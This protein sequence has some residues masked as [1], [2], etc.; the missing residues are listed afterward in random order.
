T[1]DIQRALTKAFEDA[2]PRRLKHPMR[3]AV[4]WWNDTLTQLRRRSRKARR[5]TKGANT[6]EPWEFYKKI[7]NEYNNAVQ[8][9]KRNSWRS[10]CENIEDLAETARIYKIIR[11][12]GRREPNTMSTPAGLLQDPKGILQVLL[13][14]NFPADENFR[15]PV[16]D[17][18]KMHIEGLEDWVNEETVLSALKSFNPGKAPGP[19]KIYPIQLQRGGRLIAN[20]LTQLYRACISRGYVPET[21]LG[22]ETSIADLI[23]T[24]NHGKAGGQT[25]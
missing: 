23:P 2:T 11:N 5:S 25:P 21:G 19:D 4:P 9:A 12:D 20:H 17:N 14:H 8:E 1:K 18:K 15:G 22:M 24:K 7:R 13:E 10:F 16:G 6:G 3:E